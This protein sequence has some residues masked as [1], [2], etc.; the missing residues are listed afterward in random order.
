M[1]GG[2][3]RP[4][5][6]TTG[7]IGMHEQ[8][9]HFAFGRMHGNKTDRPIRLIGCDQHGVRWRVLFDNFGVPLLGGKHR[10]RRKLA[11]ILPSLAHG[12]V[13]H[14]AD[15]ASIARFAA[16]DRNV[17]RGG[18]A[19]AIAFSI[20][21]SAAS[22]L[23]P[24]GPPACAMSGRPPP[25]LPPSA[26]EPLRTSSTALKREVKSA[27]TPTTMPALPSSVTPMM[28]TTPEPICFLPSSTRLL[29][30]LVSTPSTARASSF[31]PPTSRTPL[32][33]APP[34]DAPPPIA[35]FL[36]ASERSRSSFLRSS[37]KAAIRAGISS[38]VVRNS[39]AAV[40]ASAIAS[41][42]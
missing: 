40:F 20:A 38:S 12:C 35:S 42:A 39:P 15:P 24:S 25:P 5:D 2:K 28:A 31:A 11:E 22:A 41:L 36:R 8:Q 29:R 17:A 16:P 37:I 33:A 4:A 13:K 30:S 9:V 19:P 14:C 21:A 7:V 10:M 27:V 26:S 32:S 1:R 18:H 34:A 6:A 23:A 3:Q